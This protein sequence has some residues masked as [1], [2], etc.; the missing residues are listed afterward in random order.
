MGARTTDLEVFKMA[1]AVVLDFKDATF[2]QYDQVIE[3]M[4]LTPKGKSVPGALFHI[5]HK[6]DDGFRV[7]DVWESREQ[8]DK[9]SEEKIGPF[10]Q[11][12]GM[13]TPPDVQYH[14]V[15]NY[16]TTP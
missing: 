1:V 12:V 13:T 6:T 10:T 16:L 15:Y 14:D 9:F 5:C 3:K 2:D 4:G 11:E 8:F 7:I